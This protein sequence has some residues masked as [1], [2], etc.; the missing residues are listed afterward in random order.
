MSM[1]NEHLRIRKLQPNEVINS[2]DCGDQDLNEFIVDEA[3]YYR[4]ALLAVT[5]VLESTET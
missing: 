3:P 2:F 5:Y 1:N 4:T